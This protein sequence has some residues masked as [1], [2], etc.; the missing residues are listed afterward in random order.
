MYAVFDVRSHRVH[1]SDGMAGQ[2]AALLSG[3][4]NRKMAE[5]ANARQIASIFGVHTSTVINWVR[6]GC[7]YE[8]K[9][10][11][12]KKTRWVFDIED[13]KSWREKDLTRLKSMK[14]PTISVKPQQISKEPTSE[15]ERRFRRLLGF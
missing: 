7:P 15:F 8:S 14:E 10:F 6:R 12:K 3:G 9:E 1:D 2:I 4:G 5:K 11:L 13:V